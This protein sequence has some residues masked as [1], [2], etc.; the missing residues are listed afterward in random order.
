V[1]IA[2]YRKDLD[3]STCSDTN[4]GIARLDHHGNVLSMHQGLEI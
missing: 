2:F 3:P 4:V 1:G